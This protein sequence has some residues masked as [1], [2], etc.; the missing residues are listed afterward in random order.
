MNTKGLMSLLALS[1]LLSGCSVAPLMDPGRRMGV[2]MLPSQKKARPASAASSP[3]SRAVVSSTAAA[4]ASS[5]KVAAQYVTYLRAQESFEDAF[6]SYGKEL[7]AVMDTLAQGGSSNNVPVDGIPYYYLKHVAH[8][9]GAHIGLARAQLAAGDLAR[10]ERAA[11]NAIEFVERRGLFSGVVVCEIQEEAWK[12]LAEIY[13]KQGYPGAAADAELRRSLLFDYMVSPAGLQAY[14]EFV[15]LKFDG[16]KQMNSSNK[17]IAQLNDQ[18]QSEVANAF[19]AGLAA[20]GS[21]VSSMQEA[22]ARA[23]ARKHGYMSQE[24]AA[25]IQMAQLN[26]T[27]FNMVLA[28]TVNKAGKWGDSIAML[29]SMASPRLFQQFTDPKAGIDPSALVQDYTKRAARLGRGNP[30]VTSGAARLAASNDKMGR[31][32]KSGDEKAKKDA[33]AEFLPALTNLSNELKKVK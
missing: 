30:A 14:G 26:R 29:H 16:E 32:R 2:K 33:F 10:A 5:A 8:V 28:G 4:A 15:S 20:V 18:K 3:S 22:Q 17:M 12:L 6:L 31:A 1:A 24:N 7:D 9:A 19:A 27:M 23:D 11:M 25:T 21:A 13:T